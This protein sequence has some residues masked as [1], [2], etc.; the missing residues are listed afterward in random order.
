MMERLFLV[1]LAGILLFAIPSGI[2][3]L[4]LDRKTYKRTTPVSIMIVL[5]EILMI[6]A[7][8]FINGQLLSMTH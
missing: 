3:A 1:I 7:F 4:V 5:I 2:Y 6:F 8:L